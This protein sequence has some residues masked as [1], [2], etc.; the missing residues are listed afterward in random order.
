[1]NNRLYTHDELQRAARLAFIEGKIEGVTLGI[2]PPK[3]LTVFEVMEPLHREASALLIEKL[4]ER[5]GV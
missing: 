3:G 5:E 1:M 4:A 2:N